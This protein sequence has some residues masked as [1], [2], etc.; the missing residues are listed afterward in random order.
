MVKNKEENIQLVSKQE[1]Y[2]NKFTYLHLNKLTTAIKA[3]NIKYLEAF[4]ILVVLRQRL[5]RL[6]AKVK[7]LKICPSS[8]YD[9]NQYT[10]P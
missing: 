4:K 3:S 5:D 8:L 9:K 7:F 2:S 6:C 10:G 1:I